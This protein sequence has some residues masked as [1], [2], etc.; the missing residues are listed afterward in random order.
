MK[1]YLALIV[2]LLWGLVPASAA[3]P[4]QR[5]AGI[6]DDREPLIV[7]G[8]RALFTCSA[9]FF[10][11]RPLEDI[12]RV[13]LVDVQGLGYPAPVIDE[14]RKLVTATDISGRIVRIAAYR[15]TMGCT[16]LPPH[17]SIG[18]VT[19]LPYVQYPPPPAVA[20]LP[21]P[22][23]DQVDLPAEG[24]DA[25]FRGLAPVL[26]RAFDG[27]SYADAPGVVTTAVLILKDG[28]LVAERYRAGFGMHSGY[29][30]WS[31]AKSITAALIAIAAKKG[32]LDLD[33]PASI[34][35]WSYPGDPRQ[36]ITYKHLLWMSSGLFSGGPNTN[37]IYFGGQDIVS[38]ATTTALEAP[39]GT[40]WKYANNDTLLLLRA[41]RHLLAD[42]ERYL[43]FPYDE[44][45]HPLGMYHTRMEIDHL[46]NFVGSSQTYATARDLA[47]F[48]LLLAADG[49]WSGKRLLP[50]GWVKFSTTP[51]PTRPPAA[52]QWGYG[53]Q[54][55]LLDQMPGVPPGTYTTA[56]NKGQYVTVVAG[57]G[58]VIVRTGVD[59]D[60]KRFLQDRL[61]AAV[62]EALGK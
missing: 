16:L 6:A 17:W 15:D 12:E 60:G 18:D 49:V 2:A 57:Q 45:L 29:R 10:A 56:G 50:E 58:L 34:P 47:R 5:P 59:P 42:D 14:R 4:Y 37:A 40:R 27:R 62:V 13:E 54:F 7:A 35:E 53:A 52:N 38:A 26:E 61:V 1:R 33:A 44:L 43:R 9:H 31:T 25:R 28:K 3:P 32:I 55:W 36:A 30:T 41:L 20:E 22:A 39:P 8:Y 19:R 24:L 23:G 51:A 46:G 21:F 48:G 11:G